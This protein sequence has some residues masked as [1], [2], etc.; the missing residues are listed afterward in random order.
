MTPSYLSL[1]SCI[2]CWSIL[3]KLGKQLGGHDLDF[4]VVSHSRGVHFSLC[5]DSRDRWPVVTTAPWC[6]L[7]WEI[8]KTIKSGICLFS[9]AQKTNLKINI[10]DVVRHFELCCQNYS[11][12][13]TGWF[14]FSCPNRQHPSPF[15]PVD[16]ASRHETLSL[17]LQL[18]EEVLCLGNARWIKGVLTSIPQTLTLGFRFLEIAML[19]P[20][21]LRKEM[22][23]LVLAMSAAFS[24]GLKLWL[25]EQKST[26][27]SK[28]KA[29]RDT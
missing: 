2:L 8:R 9:A 14:S 4:V 11:H 5:Q 10:W 15:C 7:L 1:E 20:S 22:G 27:N 26:E 16:V 21:L 18:H 23:D 24:S 6:L 3:L 17:L 25:S 19:C 13:Q 12:L 29:W 28:T